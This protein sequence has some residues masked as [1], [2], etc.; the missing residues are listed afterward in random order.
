MEDFEYAETY[1]SAKSKVA[2]LRQTIT[3]SYGLTELE[4]RNLLITD[5]LRYS[6][7][8]FNIKILPYSD[9]TSVAAKILSGT[10][11]ID[12]DN[13]RSLISYNGLMPKKR[14]NFTKLHELFHRLQ[15]QNGDTYNLQYSDLLEHQ[16]YNES[17]ILEETEANYGAFLLFCTTDMLRQK[18]WKDV[19]FYRLSA[20]LG[21]SADALGIRIINY[22][23][24][25]RKI[26][27]FV[28]DKIVTDFKNDNNA[29]IK[30]ALM[31]D[32]DDPDRQEMLE[33]VYSGVEYTRNFNFDL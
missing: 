13:D 27:H 3:E 8:G 11:F 29:E 6:A 7:N 17:V 14:Q 23:C 22:L 12:K 24:F 4:T 5:I 2:R 18:I 10:L 30:L 19:S 33:S 16:G 31:D 21:M 15:Y 32:E 1:F 25:E 26:T 20:F 28:A 9:F